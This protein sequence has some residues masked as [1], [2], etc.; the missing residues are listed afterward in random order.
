MILS[1]HCHGIL[2]NGPVKDPIP[3]GRFATWSNLTRFCLYIELIVYL[4]TKTLKDNNDTLC[5]SWLQIKKTYSQMITKKRRR[6]AGV[7]ISVTS[8]GEEEETVAGAVICGKKKEKVG[9]AG[10]LR[11]EKRFL[12]KLRGQSGKTL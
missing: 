3:N 9:G 5:F 1:H 8:G 4:L 2:N 7:G 11:G 10:N 6:F 12:R